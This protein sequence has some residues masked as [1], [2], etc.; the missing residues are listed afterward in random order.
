MSADLSHAQL[1]QLL[2][3][4]FRGLPEH[5][6]GQNCIY[7]LAEGAWAAF[8]VFFN[9]ARSFLERRRDA[10]RSHGRANAA[11]L[12]G[13]HKTPSDP[14]SRNLLDPLAP[15]H[16]YPPCH[17]ILQRLKVGGYLQAYQAFANNLLVSL[18]GVH[19]FASAA[20]HCPQCKVTSHDDQTCDSHAARLPVLVAPGNPQ[21]IS[22]EPEF[23]TPQDGAAKQDCEQQAI[24]RWIERNAARFPPFQVTI[25]TDDL[26]CS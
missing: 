13:A 22:L 20:I 16:F 3:A 19:Y 24:K 17:T 1:T 2:A 25:L 6:R 14:H 9:Q 8:I 12:F 5:R 26:H 15:E 21:V 7:R 10:S 18:D 11:S 4:T 23:I